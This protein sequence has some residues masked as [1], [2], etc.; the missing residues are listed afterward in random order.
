MASA[1]CGMSMDEEDTVVKSLVLLNR[2]FPNDPRVLYITTRYYAEL[3]NRAARR[4]EDRNPDSAEAQEIVA[5]AY[6]AK[7]EYENATAKYRK[8]LEQY[9]N[10][11][12]IHYQLALIIL[13]KP[14]G[15]DSTEEARKELEEELKSNPG[16]P[17]AEYMLGDLAWR[18]QKSEEAIE[19]FSRATKL[20]VTLSQPY[21]GLGIALNVAGR[22]SEAIESLKKYVQLSPEDPA[23]YYQL[24]IAYARTG[25]KQEAERQRGLQLEAEKKG[26]AGRASTQGGLQPH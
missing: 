6:Q 12:G 23:G 10:Q 4:L 26:N 3:A 22:Y 17:T 16:S 11:P 19:H 18:E 2:E 9:P 13:A 14:P 20:D 15:P 21:L 5:E 1:Q 24:A 8:I 7:G 25:N